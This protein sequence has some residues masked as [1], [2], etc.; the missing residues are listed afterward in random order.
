MDIHAIS[1]SQL[2]SLQNNSVY[3]AR[4]SV[5]QRDF[6][7]QE[8]IHP[9]VQKFLDTYPDVMSGIPPDGKVHRDSYCKIDLLP[10]AT[11][12]MLRSYRL[13]PLERPELDSQIEKMLE[14]I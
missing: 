9:S 13:T 10:R 8:I 14:N 3:E 1:G 4:V 2:N 11:S 6:Q 12:K 7:V 5:I